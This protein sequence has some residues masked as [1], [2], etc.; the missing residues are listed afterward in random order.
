MVSIQIT[1]AP[2]NSRPIINLI[3]VGEMQFIID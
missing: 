2:L 3:T 1:N